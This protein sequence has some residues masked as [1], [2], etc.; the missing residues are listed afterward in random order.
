MSIILPAELITNN[1][2]DIEEIAMTISRPYN[3]VVENLENNLKTEIIDKQGY[4]KLNGGVAKFYNYKLKQHNTLELPDQEIKIPEE[5]INSNSLYLYLKSDGT[6]IYKVSAPTSNDLIE[7]IPLGAI[8]SRDG[9][10]TLNQV[11]SFVINGSKENQSSLDNG[12]INLNSATLIANP[13]TKTFSR[14]AGWFKSTGRNY[15]TNPQNPNRS[16]F[17]IADTVNLFY[18]KRDGSISTTTTELQSDKYENEDGELKNVEDK[19]ATVQ[20]VLISST[21]SV[22]V[23]YGGTKFRDITDA[24]NK[25]QLDIQTKP[26]SLD[27]FLRCAVII[28]TG[29]VID[30]AKQSQVIIIPCD[31][32]G[33][34]GYFA[35]F[36]PST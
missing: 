32:R 7:T 19:K 26:S 13:S 11:F 2:S 1:K 35:P 12:L 33:N 31:S 9:G 16:Y 23:L 10:Q 27:G 6:L 36:Q 18:L 21:G 30:T 3:F 28:C 4:F 20:Q 29:K 34:V 24:Q 17:D 5:I 22:V 8:V 25:F 14:T 15:F